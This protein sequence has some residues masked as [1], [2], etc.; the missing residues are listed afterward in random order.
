MPSSDWLRYT[1]SIPWFDSEK[2]TSVRW[3]PLFFFLKTTVCEEDLD[4]S[5]ERLVSTFIQI[6]YF[7][8]SRS[9]PKVDSCRAL[10]NYHAIEIES[11]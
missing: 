4:E 6:N 5:F 3:G 8:L 7:I 11:E 9:Q 2:R 10:V 1:R